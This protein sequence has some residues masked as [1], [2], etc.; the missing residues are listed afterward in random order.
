MSRR[1]NLAAALAARLPRPVLD[2]AYRHRDQAPFKWFRAGLAARDGD[3][4]EGLEIPRGPLAGTRLAFDPRGGTA[5]W[6]GLHE[7]AVQ[8]AVLRVLRPGDVAYDIGAHVGYFAILMARAVGARG[9]VHAFEPDA[10]NRALLERSIALNNLGNRVTSSGVAFGAAVGTGSLTAGED[11]LTGSVATD[12]GTI[13][14]T[15]L[16]VYVLQDGNPP[17][18]LILVDTEGA[19]G[20]ILAGAAGLVASHR[21]AWILEAHGRTDALRNALAADGYVI[22]ILDADHLL[23]THPGDGASGV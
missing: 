9:Q 10:T 1:W 7:P 19:E 15:T 11:G 21:P 23:A 5:M 20:D 18:S 22:E 16:D 8:D 13:P 12:G 2:F 6:M 4:H 3:P 14:I 17:P